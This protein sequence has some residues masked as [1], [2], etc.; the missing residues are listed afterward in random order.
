MWVRST[1]GNG[2]NWVD[3]DEV[4]SLRLSTGFAPITIRGETDYPG[5]GTGPIVGEYPDTYAAKAALVDLVKNQKPFVLSADGYYAINLERIKQLVVSGSGSSWKVEAG[6]VVLSTHTT[7]AEAQ[8][9]AE[10]L[11]GKRNLV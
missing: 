5:S 6:S 7:E 1:L 11:I 9:A 4:V 10:A 2:N 3:L 8:A